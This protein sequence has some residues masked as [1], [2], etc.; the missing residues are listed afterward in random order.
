MKILLITPSGNPNRSLYERVLERVY[1]M[2]PPITL[3]QIEAITPEKYDVEIIDENY[4]KI[5][6]TKH[7]DLVGISYFTATAPRAYKIADKFREMG[8]KVVLGGYHA[9]AL[10]EEA[11]QHADAVVIGEA[12]ETWPKLINDIEKDRLKPFYI[13]EKPVNTDAI[14]RATL[15]KIPNIIKIGG[16]EAT[17][18]CPYGCEFCAL[19]NVRFGKIYRKKSI[20]KVVQEIVSIPYKYFIFY[21]GSLTVDM[22]YTKA[23]FKEIKHLDKKFAAFGHA[24]MVDDE[25]F[26][27]IASDAGCIAWD[28]GFESIYQTTIDQLKKGTNVVKKYGHVVKKLHEYGMG[29][30]GSFAFGF[31]DHSPNVFDK[32]LEAIREWDIDS[33]GVTILTPLPGTKFYNRMESEGRILTKDWEKYDMYHVVF[34]PKKMTPNELY[35]GTTRFID[36]YYSL[37]NLIRRLMGNTK[38]LGIISSQTMNYHLLSSRAIYKSAFNQRLLQG[39]WRKFIPATPRVH[40]SMVK[41]RLRHF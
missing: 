38:N 31:D 22:N 17:R 30:I 41:K 5:D 11:K 40:P 26:L 35:E 1:L 13:L 2:W 37:K 34:Q 3:R 7:Y 36:E 27:K 39:D 23:L 16:I 12:E 6:Y 25:E 21:D 24:N 18:G 32:T 29:V 15:T 14:P 9:S 8:T 28:I 10:P 33:I 4:E 20:K 19:S